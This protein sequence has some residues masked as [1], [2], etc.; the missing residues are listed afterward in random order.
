[1]PQKRS[2]RLP[3]ARWTPEL[4][5]FRLD[6]WSRLEAALGRA[7]DAG[8]RA[9]IVGL[10]RK[11]LKME[12]K[13]RAAPTVRDEAAWLD[14]LRDA[15]ANL[16]NLVET[17]PICNPAARYGLAEIQLTLDHLTR[18]A[19]APNCDLSTLATWLGPAVDLVKRR[20]DKDASDGTAILDDGNEIFKNKRVSFVDGE[21]WARLVYQLQ[22]LFQDWGFPT[23]LRQDDK[24]SKPKKGDDKGHDKQSPFAEFFYEIQK[25]F[26]VV[27]RRHTHS[28]SALAKAMQRAIK[29]MDRDSEP[30]DPLT[31]T[32]K[33]WLRLRKGGPSTAV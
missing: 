30:L 18:Q 17:V 29:K 15:A 3:Y 22:N 32:A 4:F 20:K 9:H 5:D 31:L 16:R 24:A 13:E 12:G 23:G 27:A 7:I 6:D 8:Q 1:M 21:T 28:V 26:P 2:P 14:K 25:S 10:V 33:E 19:G 11:Y